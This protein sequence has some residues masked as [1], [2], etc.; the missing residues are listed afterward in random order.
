MRIINEASIEQL[1]DWPA[2]ITTLEQGLLAYARGWAEQPVRQELDVAGNSKLLIMPAT[3]GY[4][5]GGVKA[6][7]VAE[8]NNPSIQGACLLFDLSTGAPVALLDGAAL[9]LWR[10]AA[11]TALATRVLAPQESCALGIVGTGRQ[12]IPHI[13]AVAAV[14]PIE[15]INLWG[16]DRERAKLLAQQIENSGG[17]QVTL[18]ESVEQLASVSRIICTLTAAPEPLLERE[19]IVEGT[20]I[21]AVGAHSANSR[22]LSGELVAAARCF[23]DFS[24]AARSE[25]GE[26]IMAQAEGLI[27]ENYCLGGLPELLEGSLQGRA[28]EGDITLFK[29]LGGAVEDI[30]LATYVYKQA[31]RRNVGELIS[32]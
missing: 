15:R 21:N 31:C 27:E 14:R 17:A 5:Y 28:A 29:S 25:A 12:V 18:C 10:T 6:L 7:T 20:H 19:M 32:F 16:R 22:E 26:F 4:E 30:A 9:T 23:V 1:L 24:D 11:A 13:E 2:V 8:Q 3:L